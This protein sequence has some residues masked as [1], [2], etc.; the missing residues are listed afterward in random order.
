MQT[1]LQLIQFPV[2]FR[3]IVAFDGLGCWFS[4]DAVAASY[5]S[6]IARVKAS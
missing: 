5:P 4:L 1:L 3:L 6:A 2:E